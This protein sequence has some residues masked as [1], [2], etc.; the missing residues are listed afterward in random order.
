MDGACQMNPAGIRNDFNRLAM[1]D[2]ISDRETAEFNSQSCRQQWPFVPMSRLVSEK[3]TVN[4]CDNRGS[5][6]VQVQ[7]IVI[8]FSRL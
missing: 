4:F 7:S 8:G 5:W 6:T 3:F 1:V 2:S